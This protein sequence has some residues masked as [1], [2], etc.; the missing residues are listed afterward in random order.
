MTEAIHSPTGLEGNAMGDDMWRAHI[1]SHIPRDSR[2]GGVMTRK[3]YL[4][5]DDIQ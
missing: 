1:C 4:I 2:K 3:K 5:G